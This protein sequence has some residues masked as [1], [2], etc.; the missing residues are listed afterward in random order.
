MPALPGTPHYLP[1]FA[2]SI[3]KGHGNGLRRPLS[4]KDSLRYGSTVRVTQN[5]PDMNPT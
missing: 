4:C 3:R 2:N 5:K 1:R